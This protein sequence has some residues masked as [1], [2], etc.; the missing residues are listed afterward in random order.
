MDPPPNI[1]RRQFGAKVP[2]REDNLKVRFTE[3]IIKIETIIFNEE[4]GN[5][6]IIKTKDVDIQI[7]K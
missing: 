1:R 6:D 3:D 4:R 7:K 5:R 2:V